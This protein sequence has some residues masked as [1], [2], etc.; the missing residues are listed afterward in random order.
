V[1][2]NTALRLRAAD[3]FQNFDGSHT[4]NGSPDGFQRWSPIF[5]QGLDEPGR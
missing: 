3:L 2:D 1:L 5:C 4:R